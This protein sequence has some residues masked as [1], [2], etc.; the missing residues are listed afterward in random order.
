MKLDDIYEEIRAEIG[1]EEIEAAVISF[2]LKDAGMVNMQG[3]FSQL[4]TALCVLA[5]SIL[6]RA[7]SSQAAA[8][9]RITMMAV[10]GGNLLKDLKEV[11]EL[12]EVKPKG[13]AS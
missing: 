7:P 9:F 3:E 10:L 1:D 4:V 11:D 13:R 8:A 5:H 12:A 6:E 2:R